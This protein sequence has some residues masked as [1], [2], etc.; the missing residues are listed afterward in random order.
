MQVSVESNSEL[1]RT[2]TVVVP[3]V[4]IDEAI[5]KRLDD[6]K[7]NVRLDGFR[8]GK[9]PMHVVKSKF[10][11]SI[12]AEALSEITQSSFYKAV[13]Q[14]KIQPASAPV[15]TPNE[16]RTEEG[17][18]FSASFEVYPE[19]KVN[20][21]EDLEIETVSAE[22]AESDVDEMIEKLRSQKSD[23]KEID[24]KSEDGNR[25]VISFDGLVND[26]PVSE[27]R[28]TG[29]PVILGS[30]SM[31]EGFEENLTAVSAGDKVSFDAQFPEDY[32][33][34]DFAG[35]TGHFNVEVEKVEAS[36]LPEV[37]AEFVKGFGVEDGDLKKFREDLI[38]NMKTELEQT[39][40]GKR[41]E[42]VMD[43][44]IASNE[45]TVP[46]AMVDAEINQ[47]ITSF[48]EKA[49][50]AQQPAQP[51]LPKELFEVQATKRVQ[52]GM[53][54]SEV[55]KENELKADGDRVRAKIESF[56]KSYPTPEDVVNWYYSNQEELN[57]VENLVLEDQLVD[58]VLEK[59]KSTEKA[60][61]FE[62]VMGE[63]K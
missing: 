1:K 42:C 2:M 59:A 37:N 23:W 18:E 39:L 6:A 45:L 11:K 3:Q 31:I 24:S 63:K 48:N 51:D 58:F 20:P 55:I 47:M 40:A 34:K 12:K 43:A 10:G 46:E 35:Q 27:E 36:E 32:A 60:V 16:D 28:I 61:S 33:E 17:F 26:K 5:K 8:A 14:E 22:V 21:L 15:I 49:A 29:F 54:L 19:V 7:R 25:V 9:V 44:I 38:D 53:L 56:A 62:E 41:K 4:E 57:K 50:Q 13:M 52:L 30:K